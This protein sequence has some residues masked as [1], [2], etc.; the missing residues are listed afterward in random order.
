MYAWLWWELIAQSLT[1]FI[2][3]S[4]QLAVSPYR[5]TYLLVGEWKAKIDVGHFQE[6]NQPLF[7]PLPRIRFRFLNRTATSCPTLLTKQS[8]W[9]ELIDIKV[10]SALKIVIVSTPITYSRLC[11]AGETFSTQ[12]NPAIHKKIQ[13]K[14]YQSIVWVESFPPCVNAYLIDKVFVN[15]FCQPV[16]QCKQICGPSNTEQV[17]PAGSV[18]LAPDGRSPCRLE[19]LWLH[20]EDN[21]VLER[22]IRRKR[23]QSASHEIGT[24]SW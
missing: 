21:S 8:R 17:T 11:T 24:W 19:A 23:N 9:D 16:G 10:W 15:K 13:L 1:Y 6:L 2:E 20:T 14:V 3:A 5:M 4:Y 22:R 7:L 18:Q 12:F